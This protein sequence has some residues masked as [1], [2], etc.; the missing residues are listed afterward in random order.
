VEEVDGEE[1]S[2]TETGV[3]APA[4]VI[5]TTPEAAGVNPTMFIARRVIE[6]PKVLL[7]LFIAHYSKEEHLPDL[8]EGRPV[9]EAKLLF[10]QN[11]KCVA[12][13]MP[14]K[15]LPGLCGKW[16]HICIDFSIS[17]N[18]HCVIFTKA[19]I[20]FDMTTV[21]ILHM[22]VCYAAQMNGSPALESKACRK[23]RCL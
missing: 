19:G 18:Q 15:D 23:V 8:S 13:L 12:Y 5:I 16:T 6:N 10:W 21:F 7:P 4:V 14:H 3:K 9:P 17:Q 11:L 2:E 20:I 22:W 1:E